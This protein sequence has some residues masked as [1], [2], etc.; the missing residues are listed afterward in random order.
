MDQIII[1][2]GDVEVEFPTITTIL[3]ISGDEGVIEIYSGAEAAPQIVAYA[4]GPKGEQGDIT[5]TMTALRDQTQAL[6]DAAGAA[7]VAAKT[8]EDNAQASA[9]AASTSATAAQTAKSDTQTLKGDVITLKTSVD[10]ATTTALS[11]RDDAAQSK[12]DAAA[13]ATAAGASQI[14]AKTS[15]TN[16]KT[17][18]TNAKTSETNAKT[19]ET[20][21]ANSTQTSIDKATAAAGSAT[22]AAASAAAALAS[23]NAAVTSETN[24]KTSEQNAKTS[25]TN[26]AQSKTDAATAKT[27]AETALTASQTAKTAAEA[28]RD[29]ASGSQTDSAASASDADAKALAAAQSATDAEAA[30][31]AA[32]TSATNASDA[33]TVAG[34]AKDDAVTA[35]TDAIA[36]KTG[37][38]LAKNDAVSADTSAT[39]AKNDVDT[40]R[41]EILAATTTAE[42]AKTD[43]VNAANNAQGF[44]QAASGS[45]IAAAASAQAAK[46][47]ADAVAGANP[48]NYVLKGNNGSDFTDPAQFRTNLSLQIKLDVVAASEAQAGVGTDARLWTAQRVTQAVAAY[49]APIAHQHAVADVTGLQGDL[50]GIQANVDALQTTIATKA[51]LNSPALTGAPTAPTAPATT[52]TTQIATT[53]FVKNAIDALING[54][55]GALDTINELAT[56]LGNDPNFVTTITNQLAGK[57]NSLGFTPVQQGTGTGQGSNAVKIGWGGT[58]LLV[59]IDAANYDS[60]WPIDISGT[61]TF[62]T[63]STTAAAGTNDTRIATTA[64]VQAALAAFS[65]VPEGTVIYTARATA[66]TGY[67]KANGAAISRT[68]YAALFAA[69]GTT[70][71]AGDGSTTFNVPDM[72]G[73]VPRGLDDGRGLDT[74][75]VLGSYQDSQNLTHTHGTSDPGHIHSISDPGHAH[76]VA[77]PGH[78]HATIGSSGTASGA[79]FTSIKGTANDI[80]GYTNAVGTGIGIYAAGTGISIANHVTGLTIVA[81]GGTEARMRNVALLA[82]IKY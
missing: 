34:Q 19:S 73:V 13:S 1:E 42:T 44:A 81:S 51:P 23:K 10:A 22:D 38:E 32:A 24:A 29:A 68:T 47:S 2:A 65:S 46:D 4:V 9:Q 75:R 18:E 56:A 52:V 67:M 61:A 35:K 72:R 6:S 11:A 49:A 77:D 78:A 48:Q 71:G 55:P 40:A 59:Q 21:V 57:Q 26:A 37:A 31:I 20:N 50:D 25:E 66:P 14:A 79:S 54:A 43:A 17:S 39:T 12:T 70:H 63:N 33:A 30:K 60:I 28:A 3:E 58:K 64:F 41:G 8:S 62:A 27:A 7:G 69:I 80:N 45:E 36:A 76:G 74:S 16:A 5:P 82:C 53:A 15:E